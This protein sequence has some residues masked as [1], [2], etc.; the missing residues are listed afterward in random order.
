MFWIVAMDMKKLL[1]IQFQALTLQNTKVENVSHA[2]IKIIVS[3]APDLN[4]TN[5]HYVLTDIILIVVRV[6]NAM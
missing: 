6:F 1:H 2:M 5:V 3:N 4:L